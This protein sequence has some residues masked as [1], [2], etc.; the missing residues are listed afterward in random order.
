MP[1]QVPN[2]RL[3]AMA[4]PSV[5]A[6]WHAIGSFALTLD[7]YQAIGQRE[8]GQL[9][10][11]VKSEFARNTAPLQ[12]LSL[13]ELRACLFF[14]QRRFHH[15]GWEPEGSDIEYV[16]AL[17][18]T[19]RS[20]IDATND[21]AQPPSHPSAKISIECD[22]IMSEAFVPKDRLLL[23]SINKSIKHL[24][25]YDATRYAWHVDLT[26]VEKVDLVL[27]CEKQVVKGVFIVSRWL[28]A[29]PGE[30]TKRNFPGFKAT[31]KGQ[32]WGFEGG[33]AGEADQRNYRGKRVPE[34]LRIGQNGL[35][36]FGV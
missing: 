32:A 23:V 22:S 2:K 5:T 27:G 35:R 14:E 13:T 24:S 1:D 10:N 15:F 4:V 21:S 16:H 31:H 30:P 34:T 11:R 9:A 6:S 25:V 19:I 7:G 3:K 33:E 29:S 20:R 26:K 28:D 8:C 18:E 17:L 36:Y 12:S